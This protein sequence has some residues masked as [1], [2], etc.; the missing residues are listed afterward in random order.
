MVATSCQPQQLPPPPKPTAAP[1]RPSGSSGD[2]RHS[3]GH[4]LPAGRSPGPTQL[5]QHN[6]NDLPATPNL[7]H[8][9]RHLR[10]PT[11]PLLFSAASAHS[12]GS[13]APPLS[14]RRFAKGRLLDTFAATS[15]SPF[16]GSAAPP[17]TNSRRP[18][19]KS[20]TWHFPTRSLRQS[21]PL[22]PSTHSIG[23]A[24]L[25]FQNFE[26]ADRKTGV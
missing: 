21:T 15:S 4:E 26:T 10:Q 2:E 7:A 19:G 18:H 6:L 17:E 12:P 13:A 20:R 5:R 16:T 8:L 9:A 14:N 24:A 11:P 3:R 23:A 22:S 25:L 1:Q